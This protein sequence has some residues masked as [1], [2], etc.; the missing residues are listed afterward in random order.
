MVPI[1]IS[2][3]SGGAQGSEGAGEVLKND[4]G[5][6]SVWWQEPFQRFPLVMRLETNAKFEKGERA[7]NYRDVLHEP[8]GDWRAQI[9]EY[10]QRLL[11]CWSPGIYRPLDIFP[12]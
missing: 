12:R 6:V 3:C 9:L 1:P 8:V 2:T 10:K 4:E 5:M 7:N 11:G